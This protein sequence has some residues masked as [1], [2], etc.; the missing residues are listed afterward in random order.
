MS[1]KPI[2]DELEITP[3]DSEPRARRVPSGRAERVKAKAAPAYKEG[4]L[5]EPLAKAYAAFAIGL[6]PFAPMSANQVM[7]NT[8]ACAEAW[9]EWAK[10][11]PTVRR[12]LYPFLNVSGG[13]KVFAAHLP[14]MIAVGLETGALSRFASM[15]LGD[16]IE[17]WLR[18]STEDDYND[19]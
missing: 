5:V 1:D 15:G 10:T 6:M 19:D 9:D 4:A 2:V 12:M 13:A 3:I 16:R 11:S 14:I 17:E 7:R 18:D 8:E